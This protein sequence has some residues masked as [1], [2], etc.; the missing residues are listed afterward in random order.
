MI[1]EKSMF[2]RLKIKLEYKLYNHDFVKKL[3]SYYLLSY[4]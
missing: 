3:L 4:D 2:S 1:Q